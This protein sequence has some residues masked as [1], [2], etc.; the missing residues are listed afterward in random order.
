MCCL[1]AFIIPILFVPKACV[2]HCLRLISFFGIFYALF[3]NRLEVGPGHPR[4][5]TLQSCSEQ[6]N[7]AAD[8]RCLARV[9]LRR[10]TCKFRLTAHAPEDSQF[11]ANA[12]SRIVLGALSG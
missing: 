7:G 3:E 4:S 10:H 12:E 1:L 9:T 5:L 8:K 11:I 6:A 2:D